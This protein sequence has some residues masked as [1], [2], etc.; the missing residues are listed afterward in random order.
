MRRI[1]WN[2]DKEDPGKCWWGGSCEVLTRVILRFVSYEVLTRVIIRGADQGDPMTCWQGRTYEVLVRMI[3]WSADKGDPVKCW[4]GRSY[5]VLTRM[6]LWGADG[7]SCEVLTRMIQRSTNKDDP[8]KCWRG[9]SYVIVWGAD[10]EDI[11]P[12]HHIL[13]LSLTSISCSGISTTWHSCISAFWKK[14]K[15]W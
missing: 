12:I 2:A 3:L 6:I 7:W 15:N 10:Q 4:Q 13:F 9:W 1:P 5:E 11:M 14:P 8:T